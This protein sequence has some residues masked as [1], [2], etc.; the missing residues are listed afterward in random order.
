MKTIFSA[1]QSV[2]P[3]LKIADIN[4]GSLLHY[5]AL[6]GFLTI[7]HLLVVNKFEI[8]QF[9]KEQNTPLM[10]AISAN[11]NDVV[12]YLLRAG[13]STSIKVTFVTGL[14]KE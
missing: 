11:K 4:D 9:D 10:L 14:F 12:N 5:S 13:A 3:K 8:D 2:D 7:C 1:S 6:K